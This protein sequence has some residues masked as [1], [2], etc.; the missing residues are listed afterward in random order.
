MLGLQS[1][2]ATNPPAPVRPDEGMWMPLLVQTLNYKDMQKLGCKLTPEQIYSLNN[3]SL[4]DAV[5][6]L[7]GF[8]TAEV[9]SSQGL[10]LTNHHCAY[11]AIQS[12][13]SVEHDYLTDG[14]WAMSKSEELPVAGLTVSFLDHVEDI[15]AKM[16]EAIA[17]EGDREAAIQM[18]TEKMEE[19]ASEGGKFRAEV[20]SMFAGN[21]FYLFV[22]KVYRDIRLV[23]APPSSVGKFGGDTDNWMWPR[24]TGDFS[25]LRIYAG[26]DNEPADFS[27]DNKPFQPKHFLPVSV[28]G[29]KEGDFAMIMGYPGSTDRYLSSYHIQQA[30][31]NDNLDVIKLL[32]T[33]LE[34]MKADMDASDEVRIKLASD[35][36]SL[37]NTWKYYEGQ[38]LGLT[39]NDLI[40]KKVASEA[41]FT[42]WV[43]A[44]A[45]RREEYGTIL[46][47]MKTA[48][49]GNKDLSRLGNYMNMA[50]FG[51]GIV[52]GGIPYWRLMNTMEK[53]PDDK[54]KWQPIIDNLLKG[55]D[56]RFKDYNKGTDEKIFAAMNRAFYNDV[57][58]ANHPSIYKD[59]SFT[60]LKGK[61]DKDR[62]DAYG[63]LVYGSTL[64]ADKAKAKAFLENP[65]LKVLK[66]DPGVKHVASIIDLYLNKL[67]AGQ[68][69]YSMTMDAL[70]QKY[71]KG[72]R[73]MDPN[74]VRYPD[75]NFTMRLTYGSVMPY[76]PRDGVN[77]D[78]FTTQKGILEKEIPGDDEFDVPAKLK[79]LLVRKDFGR[80]G[81][82]ATGNLVT[83]FLSN[84]DI[85]GGNSGSPVINGEGQLIGIAFDGNWESM[86]G[87]LMFDNTTQRTISVDIRYV[88]FIIDKYAGAKHL[89]DEMSVV[90]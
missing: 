42:A 27:A 68:A 71:L 13:S 89:V 30:M 29:V 56:G 50:A 46:S 35:Y 51:P 83:C 79:D 8:C 62:F 3:A 25:M 15:T 55:L 7:G 63:S 52:S 14:F 57:N 82:K 26:A 53:F 40:G 18:Q 19:A 70:M 73:E 66:A 86:T 23:G 6:Q 77:Y 21:E 10:L 48:I 37:A 76:V 44:D 54:T 84:T 32:G 16:N 64:L 31:D 33:R 47:E 74:K 1:L 65:S 78:W 69:A 24:H 45:K 72:M 5:V 80:Y 11:D 12:H 17:A 49:E 61:G 58:P 36:A 90:E 81:D 2:R 59:K 34:I 41:K 28:K 22:Y 60:K 43:N 67:Q 88:L 39:R 9:V 4:K 75:A 20:K 85:T 38:Q 87:D